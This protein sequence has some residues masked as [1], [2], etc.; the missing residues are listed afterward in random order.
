QRQNLFG[1]ANRAYERHHQLDVGQAEGLAH[2]AQRRA[3][4]LEAFAKARRNVARGAAEAEHGVLFIGLV[5]LAAEELAV[6]VRLEIRQAHDHRLRPEGRGD[7]GDALHHLLYEKGARIGIA[8]RRLLDLALQRALELR[9]F[10][11][12]AR[13]HADLVVDDEFEARQP[14]AGVG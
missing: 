8:P 4:E 14:D 7:G 11:A 5:A 2:L 13:M 6:L 3:L 10:E 1:F 12:G 9:I